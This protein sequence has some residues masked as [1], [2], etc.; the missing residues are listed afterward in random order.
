MPAGGADGVFALLEAGHVALDAAGVAV[1][2][3]RRQHPLRRTDRG[4]MGLRRVDAEA[5]AHRLELARRYHRSLAA[6]E[7]I[8]KSRP[9]DLAPDDPQFLDIL[10]RL[11]KTDIGA[12][13]EIGID[14]VERR[15]QPLD[16]ACIGAG[17]DDQL[18]IAP[19]V[20]RGA[21]LADHLAEA[22]HLFALVMAA[23]LGRDLI[24]DVERCDPR[25]LVLADRAD[26][27]D[28]IA[29]AGIGIGDDRDADRLY[30]QP[31]EANVLRHG[32]QPQIGVAVRP[33]ITP[34]RQIDRLEPGLL[35]EPRRQRVIGA[36][37]HRVAAAGN[38]SS[39]LLS[40]R[41]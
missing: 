29:V 21:D 10:R 18:G 3:E 36:R 22:H 7:Y 38:Q 26:D 14:A 2:F 23:F 41:H 31:D 20:D 1:L 5:E 8:D 12:G 15:R 4:T 24:L 25:F 35:D 37:D 27:V 28:R 40:W 32:E 19:G 9:A 6:F 16:G 17:N 33:R 34:T 39:H 13:F 11:D 30:R